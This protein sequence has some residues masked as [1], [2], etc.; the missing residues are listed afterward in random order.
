M[1]DTGEQKLIDTRAKR[2]S[3]KGSHKEEKLALHK[4]N[5]LSGK[6][7][8]SHMC[9]TECRPLPRSHVV[10]WVWGGPKDRH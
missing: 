1:T 9:D 3:Y 8:M 7:H 6:V 10:S 5:S 2:T 4:D